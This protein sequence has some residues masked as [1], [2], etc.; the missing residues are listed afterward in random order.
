M[1]KRVKALLIGLS[2]FLLIIVG[3]LIVYTVNKP[4]PAPSP[5]PIATPKPTPAP[6]EVL[7]VD[8]T[9]SCSLSFTV[10][11]ETVV[12]ACNEVCNTTTLLCDDNLECLIADGETEGLCRHPDYLQEADCQPPTSAS[13]SISPSPSPSPS[14]SD[15]PTA[16]L[17]CVVKRVY[18]DD[19]RNTA[20]TYYLNS[21]ITDTNTLSNG[22][23]IVYNIV[24]ANTGDGEV[25]ATTIDD[26]LSSNLTYLDASS[27][28]NYD[29]TSR[30]V[31]CA[32][33]TVPGNTETSKSIRVQVVTAGTSSINNKADVYSTN[34]Q[35]DICEITV[36]TTGEIVQ[37]P[38]PIPTALPEAGVMEVTT[39]TIGVGIIFLLLGALGLLL[40]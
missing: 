14:P 36:S 21:E 19:T 33:G 22:Q 12:P 1:S 25:P 32:V 17:S 39:G 26:T 24:I 10:A 16:E 5:T 8:S 30:K 27:G 2:I 31:S 29:S 4:A 40:I 6:V 35:R 20:G 9:A 7:Q 15:S 11:G 3:V 28:C 13:P 37:P 34:G 38:S 18:E 23:T